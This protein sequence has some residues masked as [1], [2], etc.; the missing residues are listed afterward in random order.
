M[1]YFTKEE[2]EDITNSLLERPSRDT[3]KE[4]NN[5][6]NGVEEQKE[7]VK[8]EVKQIEPNIP[9]FTVEEPTPNVEQVEK[10]TAEIPVNMQN[11]YTEPTINIPVVEEIKQNV[12]EPISANPQTTVEPLIGGFPEFKIHNP[13]EPSGQNIEQPVNPVIQNTNPLNFQGNIFETQQNP[14]TYMQTAPVN[15]QTAVNTNLN[16]NPF[17][18]SKPQGIPQNNMQS[19][20]SMFGQIINNNQ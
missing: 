4:L 2:L 7:I 20:P 15:E 12:E 8:E 1:N 3:L 6:Y 9:S 10:P 18:V 19:G 11:T 5:K 13:A 14:N 16:S 17:F